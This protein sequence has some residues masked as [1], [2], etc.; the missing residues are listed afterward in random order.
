MDAGMRLAAALALTA[1]CAGL[2]WS[3]AQRQTRRV[4]AL[5]ALRRAVSRLEEDMLE[6]RLP[7]GEALAASGHALFVRAARA[8]DGQ[9]PGEALRAAA[10]ALSARGG[11]LD[12]L[13][14]AD[15]AA[16]DRLAGGLGRGSAERQRL[17]LAE[18]AEELAALSANA[19]KLA[20]ERNR[21]YVSLGALGGLA[22]AVMLV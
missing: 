15:M 3:A 11:Q 12:S 14:P 13:T 17:L 1:A 18:T 19:E 10:R 16:I 22:L 2:G 8:G 7:L 20:A 21:L 9:P 6:K 5:E 4:K